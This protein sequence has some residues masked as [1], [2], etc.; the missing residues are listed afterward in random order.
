MVGTAQ[1]ALGKTANQAAALESRKCF[2]PSQESSEGRREET[3][4]NLGEA[5][6]RWTQIKLYMASNAC[7]N[8]DFPPGSVNKA[9]QYGTK[10]IPQC[11]WAKY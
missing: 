1:L 7:R 11:N 4:V 3:R 10:V 6:T 8:F 2:Y 9:V 5:S